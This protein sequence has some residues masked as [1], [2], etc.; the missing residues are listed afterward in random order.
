VVPGSAG[1]GGRY[2]WSIQPPMPW[3][4][5]SRP[6][7]SPHLSTVGS[8]PTLL[9]R[10]GPQPCAVSSQPQAGSCCASGRTRSFSGGLLP[11][12]WEGVRLQAR[13]CLPPAPAPITNNMTVGLGS[14]AYSSTQSCSTLPPRPQPLSLGTRR[15]CH[16][17]PP[18]LRRVALGSSHPAP[19]RAPAGEKQGLQSPTEPGHGLPHSGAKPG[20]G[21]KL[22]PDWCP[23]AQESLAAKP[24]YGLI[25]PAPGP[26]W[27]DRHLVQHPPGFPISA[28]RCQAQQLA[29]AGEQQMWQPVV[30]SGTKH[31]CTPTQKRRDPARGEQHKSYPA[32]PLPGPS[33]SPEV[34]TST[35]TGRN[36][37]RGHSRHRHLAQ[38]PSQR[39]H[40]AAAPCPGCAHPHE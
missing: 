12:V 17:S 34:H 15:G 7:S 19:C 37:T 4:P 16:I 9:P 8:P 38:S 6:P 32:G 24:S 13:C 2:K 26:K 28:G 39:P 21:M 22:S 14:C 11:P 25:C 30:S 40:R 1:L 33:T 36:P 20:Q 35:M 27:V 10:G 3:L 23:A 5:P 31:L 18:P 29:E